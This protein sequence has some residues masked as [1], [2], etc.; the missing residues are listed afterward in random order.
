MLSLSDVFLKSWKSKLNRLEDTIDSSL[1]SGSYPSQ[2]YGGSTLGSGQIPPLEEYAKYTILLCLINF[3]LVKLVT[4]KQFR[5]DLCMKCPD[6]Y[7]CSLSGVS[8][9]ALSV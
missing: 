5:S 6:V 4:S 9:E 1:L 8:V 3:E 7:I 2:G